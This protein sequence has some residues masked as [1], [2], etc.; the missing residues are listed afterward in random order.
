[1]K[2][3][4]VFYRLTRTDKRPGPPIHDRRLARTALLERRCF[5]TP[6]LKP[7][8][9]NVYAL[10]GVGPR[11]A[12]RIEGA[13]FKWAIYVRWGWRVRPGTPLWHVIHYR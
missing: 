4:H 8:P 13:T 2:W 1:V 7:S 11:I 6:W 5:P 12:I 9:V 3:R 10:P